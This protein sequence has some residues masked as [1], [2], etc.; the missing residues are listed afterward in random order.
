MAIVPSDILEPIPASVSN[1]ADADEAI[2]SLAINQ[3]TLRKYG[4]GTASAA[5]MTASAV[6]VK[7]DDL[8]S[9]DNTDSPV[10]LSGLEDVIILDS[11][12]GNITVNFPASGAG[13]IQNGHRF[14]FIRTS[15]SNAITIGRNGNTIN[16]AA[17]D[18]TMT[19]AA[20]AYEDF[21]YLSGD[22]LFNVGN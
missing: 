13:S 18:V 8:I 7:D 14:R 17:A 12:A 4:Y 10:T 5:T 22:D 15:A 6:A 20:Y 9:Y 19:A 21:S 11:S 3:E 16:G 2:S 1:L